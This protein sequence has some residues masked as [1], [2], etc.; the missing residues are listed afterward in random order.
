MLTKVLSVVVIIAVLLKKVDLKSLSW[1]DPKLCPLGI[2]HIACN[3]SGAFNER[4]EPDA[5]IIDLRPHRKFILHEHNKRRNFIASGK[6]PGY[7]P[8]AKMASL[9]WDDELA[10]LAEMNVRTCVVEHEECK[11][12]YRFRNIGQNL[13]GIDR[14]RHIK[15]NIQEVIQRGMSLWFGEHTLINSNYIM[16]F[17][18]DTNFEQYGHFAEFVLDRNTHVGC[19]MLRYTHP[20]YTFL[21]IYNTACNYASIY[22]LDV[23]VYRVGKPASMCTTGEHPQYPALCSI[24]EPFNPNYD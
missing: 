20:V 10:F 17:K 3:N 8:A 7:Y 11:N 24:N 1:C 23:P 22:A 5:K 6:L 15:A 21:H 14:P 2:Q 19:A 9:Q 16:K 18:A 12:S 13:V 4:C